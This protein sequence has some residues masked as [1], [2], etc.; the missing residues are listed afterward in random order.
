MTSL[1]LEIRLWGSRRIVSLESV[2]SANPR[3]ATH[4]SSDFG[5]VFEPQF[6]CV[7]NLECSE[8]W[9]IMDVKCLCLTQSKYS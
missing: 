9:E 7:Q 1:E 8:G 3:P 6:L 2:Q 5:Q 4:E